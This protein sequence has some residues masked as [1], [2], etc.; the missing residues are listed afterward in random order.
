MSSYYF[1]VPKSDRNREIDLSDVIREDISNDEVFK[2]VERQG[3]RDPL[4]SDNYFLPTG[5]SS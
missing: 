1:T 3:S 2:I 4:I 5:K